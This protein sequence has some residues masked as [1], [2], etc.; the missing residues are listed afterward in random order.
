M[1]CAQKDGKMIF[2]TNVVAL[3]DSEVVF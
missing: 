1:L 2:H 3:R